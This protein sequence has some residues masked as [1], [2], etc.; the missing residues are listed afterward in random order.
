MKILKPNSKMD[1]I[2]GDFKSEVLTTYYKTIKETAFIYRDKEAALASEDMAYYVTSELHDSPDDN[3]E[4]LNWG[5]TCM[6]PVTVAGECCMTRGHF[7]QDHDYP[8]YYLC[9]A[10]EGYLLCW[11]G[12]NEVIAYHFTPGCL[13]YID[14][15]MAH[16]LINTGTEIFK[17]AACWARNSGHDYVTIEE[18]GFPVRAFIIDGK[19]EWVDND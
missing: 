8:E 3:K 15:R 5:M 19:L 18:R 2:D 10:G 17:V 14:G 16:R 9:T 4:A 7:H 13:Q 11:D 12:E 6:Y 1:F